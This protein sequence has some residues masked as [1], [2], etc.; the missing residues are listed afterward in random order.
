ML[1][2]ESHDSRTGSKELSIKELEIPTERMPRRLTWRCEEV[3]LGSG[4]YAEDLGRKNPIAENMSLIN[5]RYR[6]GAMRCHEAG[7]SYGGTTCTLYS[8]SLRG[9]HVNVLSCDLKSSSFAGS[10][11]H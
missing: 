9:S 3:A 8:R 11:G 1:D 5:A 2:R 10:K 7:Q 4:G 6:E